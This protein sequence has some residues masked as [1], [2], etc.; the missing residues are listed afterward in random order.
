L[1]HGLTTLRR[2]IDSEKWRKDFG[3][4]DLVRN[5]VYVEKPKVFEYYPQYYH[6]IDKVPLSPNLPN[7]PSN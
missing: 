1:I 7:F 4:D 2:F 3:T 6:K 5:F